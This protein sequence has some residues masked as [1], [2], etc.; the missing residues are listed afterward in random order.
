MYHVTEAI[1]TNIM[2]IEDFDSQIN[3]TF[4]QNFPDMKEYFEL[5]KIK[6]EKI[7][8]DKNI[9]ED[10]VINKFRCKI[11]TFVFFTTFFFI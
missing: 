6:A 10:V 5:T 8:D 1:K 3:E 7:M 11:Q 9:D 4:S 2:N